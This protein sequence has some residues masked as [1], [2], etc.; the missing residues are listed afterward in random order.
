MK[1]NNYPQFGIR[2]KN[3][4]AKR[5]SSK[6]L[7]AN[8]ALI[9]INDVLENHEGY[10]KDSKMSEPEKGKYVRSC[11]GTPLHRLLNLIDKRILR[12]Y[13]KLAPH[14][15]FG[16]LSKKNH[17][18]AAHY[19]IGSKKR[20][21]LIKLDIKRFYEQITQERIFYFFYK[22]AGC[23]VR[24]SRLL[25]YICC[26]T[27]GAKGNPG[28][29]RVLAR[30]FS[31]SSRLAVWANLDTFLKLRWKLQAELGKNDPKI[32]VYVDDIGISVADVSQT[33]LEEIALMMAEILES[34]DANQP[35]P[36]NNEK[37]DIMSFEKNAEHLGLRLGR[38]AIFMGN[39]IMSKIR[40]IKNDYQRAEN[41]TKFKLMSKRIAYRL[42]Q[43]QIDKQNEQ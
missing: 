39:K 8:E 34:S 22:K 30:G 25:A 35:L 38:K 4:L 29:Q 17:I 1:K 3:E 24:A 2:S 7:P 21:S 11:V 43:K 26:V 36:I 32:A 23:S 28:V 41:N 40:K 15:I 12:P 5:I 14:F 31:T 16:G 9:L 10:W 13:D 33:K 20:R 27:Q 18:Q 6:S 37:L 19:L 42:Y